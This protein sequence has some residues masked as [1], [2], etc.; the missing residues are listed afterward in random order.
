MIPLVLDYNPILP[1]I[2]KIIKKHAYLPQ[3]SPELIGIFPPKSIFPAYRRTKNLK[4]L[5]APSKQLETK[6]QKKPKD[7]LNVTKNV[8]IYASII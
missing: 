6:I 3:S 8:V 2:Q 4:E 7:V 1:G 5:L